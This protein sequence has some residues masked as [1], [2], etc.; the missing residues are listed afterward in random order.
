LSRDELRAAIADETVLRAA[1]KILRR[2]E[3]IVEQD[4]HDGRYEITVP[5]MRMYVMQKAEEE[6]GG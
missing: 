2:R 4:G 1:V 6:W 5:L 3:I